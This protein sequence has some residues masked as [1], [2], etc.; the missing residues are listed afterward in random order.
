MLASAAAVYDLFCWS[1]IWDMSSGAERTRKLVFTV[2]TL[3]NQ[4]V[5]SRA[6]LVLKGIS[7][8]PSFPKGSPQEVD[9]RVTYFT[10]D[11]CVSSQNQPGDR[12]HCGR[13]MSSLLHR[14]TSNI[15]RVSY[16]I[17]CL[18]CYSYFWLHFNCCIHLYVENDSNASFVD[19]TSFI[20]GMN[21]VRGAPC[22]CLELHL[23]S[24]TC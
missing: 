14:N 21:L 17:S 7:D 22:F 1:Q 2:W 20:V 24:L 15:C 12:H 19:V 10:L 5:W 9:P 6:F 4:S 18:Y 3:Q 23:T 8:A 11:A 13:D 16:L